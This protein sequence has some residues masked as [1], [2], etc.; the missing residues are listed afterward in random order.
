M[1]PNEQSHRSSMERKRLQHKNELWVEEPR[2]S[3]MKTFQTKGATSI[4]IVARVSRTL[5]YSR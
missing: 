5:R 1:L 2:H 3:E 4:T